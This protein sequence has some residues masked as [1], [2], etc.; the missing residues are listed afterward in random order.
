MLH[1]APLVRFVVGRVRAGLPLSV[2]SA[3]LVSDGIIGL[4][5]AIEKFDLTRNLTFQTYAVPRIRGAVL[6]GLRSADWVPRQVRESIRDIGVAQSA[7]EAR[8]GR[9]PTE[10]EVAAELGVSRRKLRTMYADS[11]HT[12]IVS[13]DGLGVSGSLD[14]RARTR[15]PGAGEEIPAGFM[16]AVRALPERD[17]VVVALYYW[18]GLSLAE[19]GQVLGVSESRVSQLRS[20]AALTLYHKLAVPHP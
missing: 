11:S 8:L 19:I 5:D 3:D 18:E 7:L 1:Y 13:L 10:A 4:M 20:R 9:L 17:Q 6:D 15:L 14:L 16:A 2:D 12:T